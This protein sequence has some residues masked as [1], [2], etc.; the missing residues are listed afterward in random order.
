MANEKRSKYEKEPHVE[1][2]YVTLSAI[3]SRSSARYI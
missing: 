1:D 2:F 3:N